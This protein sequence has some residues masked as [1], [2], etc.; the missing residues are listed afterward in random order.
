L[1]DENGERIRGKEIKEAA[2]GDV[3]RIK[4]AHELSTPVLTSNEWIAARVR[5]VYRADVHTTANPEW[6]SPVERWLN[7]FCGYRRALKVGESMKR[8]SRTWLQ[9]HTTG[10]NNRP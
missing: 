9:R 4:V 8:H 6:A 3:A 7:N 5:D 2:Q 1:F 10:I